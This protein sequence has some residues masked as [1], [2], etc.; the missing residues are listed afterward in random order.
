MQIFNRDKIQ[1]SKGWNSL[2]PSK[3]N[4]RKRNSFQWMTVINSSKNSI[5][6]KEL[7]LSNPRKSKLFERR[8]ELIKGM[9]ENK[10]F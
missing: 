9:N 10:R 4:T 2:N 8:E 1:I 5:S 3:F 6:N 7:I